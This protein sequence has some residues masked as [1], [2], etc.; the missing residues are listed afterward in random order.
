M[1]THLNVTHRITS[2]LLPQKVRCATLFAG[3]VGHELVGIMPACTGEA[4][5]MN[6]PQDQ[7]RGSSYPTC[8]FA[9]LQSLCSSL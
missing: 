1:H 3:H 7:C 2:H 8:S 4:V 9:H 5:L 6:G